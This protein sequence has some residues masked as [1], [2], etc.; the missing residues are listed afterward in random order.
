MKYIFTKLLMS[1]GVLIVISILVFATF[2]ILPGDPVN[3]ILGTNSTPERVEQLTKQLSLDKPLYERYLL[4]IQGIFRG[5]LGVSIKY[6]MPVSQILSSRLPVTI[7][8]AVMSL[9]F[10]VSISYLMGL[11]AGKN[12][13]NIVGKCIVGICNFF[14]AVPSYFLC[15]LM[16]IIFSLILKVFQTGSFIAYSDSPLGYFTYFILP[17]FSIAIP[18]SAMLIKFL[19]G[20]IYDQSKQEYIRTARSKGASEMRVLIHHNVKNALIPAVTMLGMIIADILCGSIVVEQIFNIPGIGRLLITS[21][22]AR[23]FPMLQILSMFIA[24]VV[25]IINFTV[26]IIFKLIDPRVRIE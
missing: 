5:D 15:I 12:Y 19:S 1:V 14:T 13:D 21:I 25:V 9:I 23:D 6:Q 11:I 2:Q 4:L 20:S 26:D 8:L 16:I 7:T 3:V 17:A 24:A 18:N 22:G 10:I